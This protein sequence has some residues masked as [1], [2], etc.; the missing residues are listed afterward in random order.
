MSTI[1]CQPWKPNCYTSC[2]AQHNHQYLGDWIHII[3]YIL[4]I[5]FQNGC[6]PQDNS[7]LSWGRFVAITL[8]IT[9]LVFMENARTGPTEQNA[10]SNLTQG[11]CRNHSVYVYANFPN[12]P[13]QSQYRANQETFFSCSPGHLSGHKSSSRKSS[14]P[15]RL[16]PRRRCIIAVNEIRKQKCKSRK[17]Q[18]T[19]SNR[20]EKSARLPCSPLLLQ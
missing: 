18:H 11:I 17:D 5:R 4:V 19:W 16:G 12:K 15:Y 20:R 9:V 6:S 2:L 8:C 13:N 7:L 10:Q 3:R 1:L 14:H